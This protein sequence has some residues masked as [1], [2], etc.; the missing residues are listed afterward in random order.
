[1][2]QDDVSIVW[3]CGQV[4]ISK[5]SM[6]VVLTSLEAI[7]VADE[8]RMFIRSETERATK[9]PIAVVGVGD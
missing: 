8:L 1:M 7:Q 2:M 5:R 4:R 6:Y 9:Q 3:A